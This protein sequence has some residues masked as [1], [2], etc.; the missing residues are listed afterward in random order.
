M[1]CVPGVGWNGWGW[2]KEERTGMVEEG[3]EKQIEEVRTVEN[4]MIAG[5][6]E[7]VDDEN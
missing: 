6:D 2:R 4:T 7:W 1:V 5:N 3:R